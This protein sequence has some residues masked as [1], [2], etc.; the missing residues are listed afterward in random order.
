MKAIRPSLIPLRDIF[1][2]Y[3][4]PDETWQGI[5]LPEKWRAT[6]F[7]TTTARVISIPKDEHELKENDIVLI[8]GHKSGLKVRGDYYL[9]NMKL[10]VGVKE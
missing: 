8:V 5:T 9:V 1:V 3:I 6:A 7:E 10:I 2:E 4:K